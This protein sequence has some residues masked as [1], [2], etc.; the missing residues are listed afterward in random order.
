MGVVWGFHVSLGVNAKSERHFGGV[1]ASFAEGRILGSSWKSS[2]T[3][4]PI[5]R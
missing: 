3:I 4:V 2:Q 1:H 5:F